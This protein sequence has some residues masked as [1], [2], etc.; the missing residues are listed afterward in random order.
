M[1]HQADP[2]DLDFLNA[3]AEVLPSEPWGADVYEAWIA[4]LKTGTGR[5]GK[6]LFRPLRLALTGVEQGPELKA[7]LPLIGREKAVL[8]LTGR[9]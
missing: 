8:R 4:A 7:I 5:K 3:A 1:S 2:E 9:G 6:G